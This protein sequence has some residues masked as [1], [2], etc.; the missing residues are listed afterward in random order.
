MATP[1]VPLVLTLHGEPDK[2]IS[3]P[4]TYAE[5]IQLV[6]KPN[7]FLHQLE[8]FSDKELTFRFKWDDTEVDLDE[9]A[10]D[11]IHARARLRIITP[12]RAPSIKTE[13]WSS[14]PR[15]TVNSE[16]P[17][18]RVK[19]EKSHG[20]QSRVV[21]D[22]TDDG[23]TVEEA[24]P[25]KKE[26]RSPSLDHFE[27]VDNN[28]NQPAAEMQSVATGEA[29]TQD[30]LTPEE[31]LQTG[32]N[33][34][35]GA[36]YQ[37]AAQS[38]RSPS[39]GTTQSGQSSPP[40]LVA[41]SN[42]LSAHNF[43]VH[44]ASST[45]AVRP[46]RKL[47]P[48]DRMVLED[49]N[50]NSNLRLQVRILTEQNI[51]P[52][53]FKHGAIPFDAL[54]HYIQERGYP[55]N[56]PKIAGVFLREATDNKAYKENEIKEDADVHVY[57]PEKPGIYF[58]PPEVSILNKIST[59]MTVTLGLCQGWRFDTIYPWTSIDATTGIET[60]T[61][62]VS[63]DWH[64]ITVSTSGS[65]KYFGQIAWET[66]VNPTVEYPLGKVPLFNP[67]MPDLHPKKSVVLERKFV[68]LD[69]PG[70]CGINYLQKALSMQMGLPMDLVKDFQV[71]FHEKFGDQI[72]RLDDR[73]SIAISFVPQKH[74]E[75]AARI[76]I[77]P[78]PDRTARVFMLFG[79]V[80][81]KQKQGIWSA[82]YHRTRNVKNA[83]KKIN[84]AQETGI[85]PCTLKER[86]YFRAIIWGMMQVP[87]ERLINQGQGV[88]SEWS[89]PG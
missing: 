78:P 43:A 63:M 10:F 77:T 39:Q 74:M 83:L 51:S 41:I 32:V 37:T 28:D 65:D 2:L 45:R 19:A 3:K 50:S 27:G 69:W 59:E 72:Q 82:W 52:C 88:N 71:Y 38:R 13:R 25:A 64:G 67:A 81:T 33:L 20:G 34:Q 75:D 29:A 86:R 66:R 30:H 49:N 89:L 70:S 44:V 7:I 17:P 11:F 31:V 68:L 57:K 56:R 36:A 24:V 40:P 84:W 48:L 14:T 18:K 61:W 79:A 73:F 9:S 12:D 60:A 16:H 21:I 54:K 15:T 46:D 23:S 42:R 26:E 55:T 76:S 87:M 5:L 80:D 62:N 47:A 35:I 85:Q 1:R 53:I 8:K 6:R 58:L 22:L 4:D